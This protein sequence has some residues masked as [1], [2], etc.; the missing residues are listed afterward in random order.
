M[1]LQ[2]PVAPSGVIVADPSSGLMM[3]TAAACTGKAAAS[4]SADAV[5]ALAPERPGRPAAPGCRPGCGSTDPA[6]AR[7]PGRLP[8]TG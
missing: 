4:A 8:G 3:G 7:A 5:Q 2:N 1:P 6:R